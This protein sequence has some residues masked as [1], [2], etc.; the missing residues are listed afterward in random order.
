M[1]SEKGIT[2]ISLVITVIVLILLLSIGFTSVI[3]DDGVI[4]K[5]Q[6]ARHAVE[7]TGKKNDNILNELNSENEA[8]SSEVPDD[9]ETDGKCTVTFYNGLTKLTSVTVESGTTV[10]YPVNEPIPEKS[11]TVSIQYTFAGTWST[12]N[13]GTTEANLTNVTSNMNVY[14]MY[15]E[16]TIY[17]DVVFCDYLGTPLETVKVVGG[18]TA[19]YTAPTRDGYTFSKWVV[20]L[21]DT[22]EATLT[23]ITKNMT[24]FAYYE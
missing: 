19:T 14:A 6:D 3:E 16:S 12:N 23:N 2:L 13:G 18:N 1:K 5:T 4:S 11:S 9:S 21:N 15:N 17:Y 10:T 7:D 24:V 8:S 22:T 20:S